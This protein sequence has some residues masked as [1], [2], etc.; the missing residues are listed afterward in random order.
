MLV[1]VS[2]AL[3]FGA[4]HFFVDKAHGKPY[5]K[6]VKTDNA[7]YIKFCF[8]IIPGAAVVFLKDRAGQEL[9]GE[10]H[11]RIDKAAEHGVLFFAAHFFAEGFDYDCRCV[12]GKHPYGGIACQLFVFSYGGAHA[13]PEYLHTPTGEPA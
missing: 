9:G 5:G 2:A 8:G 7:L 3:R 6:I 10:N 11:Q 4:E 12:D 13:G 1:S